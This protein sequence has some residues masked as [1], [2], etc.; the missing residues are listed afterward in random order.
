[1][2][3]LFRK[4]PQVLFGGHVCRAFLVY[5]DVAHFRTDHFSENQSFGTV[6]GPKSIYLAPELRAADAH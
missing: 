1:M 3:G 4:A 2:V 6:C 5:G